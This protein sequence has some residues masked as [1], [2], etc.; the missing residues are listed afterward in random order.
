MIAEVVST[1]AY[2]IVQ[3]SLTYVARPG[4][5]TGLTTVRVSISGADLEV[6]LADLGPGLVGPVTEGNGRW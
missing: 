4:D 5:P 1:A 6:E 3:E 2:R